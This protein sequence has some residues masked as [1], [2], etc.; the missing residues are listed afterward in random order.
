MFISF[1][2]KNTYPY[3]SYSLV[4]DRNDMITFLSDI[5]KWLYFEP[6]F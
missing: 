3:E 4:N 2:E 1:K 6:N 5:L